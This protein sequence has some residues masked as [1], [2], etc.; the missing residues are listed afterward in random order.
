MK[1]NN[2]KDASKEITDKQK[3]QN[4]GGSPKTS[5]KIDP[6]GTEVM[7]EDDY[8]KNKHGELPEDDQKEI[9]EK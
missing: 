6:M 3:D 1:R 9:S 7:Q 8:Q 4:T 5:E 2:D